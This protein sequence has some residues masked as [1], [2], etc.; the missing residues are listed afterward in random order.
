[1]STNTIY[2]CRSNVGEGRAQLIEFCRELFAAQGFVRFVFVGGL[3]SEDEYCM[4]P[5]TSHHHHHIH[6]VSWRH[7]KFVGK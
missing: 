5:A 1:M 4:S 7:Q 2:I 3:C 6:T